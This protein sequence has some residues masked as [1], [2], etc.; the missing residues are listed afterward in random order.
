MH[1]WAFG[2]G[3]WIAAVNAFQEGDILLALGCAWIAIVG[4]MA[5]IC[6]FIKKCKRIK[7]RDIIFAKLL[8]T[9]GVFIGVVGN[10]IFLAYKIVG[11]D[12]S[13][14]LFVFITALATAVG[15]YGIKKMNEIKEKNKTIE[16]LQM[17][18]NLNEN[19]SIVD[20]HRNAL[21]RLEAEKRKL[22]E[23]QKLLRER[24]KLNQERIKR[25]SEEKEKMKKM[26]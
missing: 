24:N 16:Q 15:A 4:D 3:G 23:E 19:K 13:F 7:N 22:E 11:E 20:N 17:E 18:R 12:T 5:I 9:M 1:F 6:I 21:E 14:G 26:E 2:V 8:I 10:I 25:R